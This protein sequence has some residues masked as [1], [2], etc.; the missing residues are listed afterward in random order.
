MGVINSQNGLVLGTGLMHEQTFPI[1]IP[2]WPI[3]TALMRSMS[4]W[5][6]S[7]SPELCGVGVLA[8]KLGLDAATTRAAWLHK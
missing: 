3:R 1:T 8:S 6:A 5:F 2:I 7:L 4:E